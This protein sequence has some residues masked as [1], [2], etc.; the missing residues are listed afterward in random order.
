MLQASTSHY[1]LDED[2]SKRLILKYYEFLLR[3]RDVAKAQFGVGILGNLH[4]FPLNMGPARRGYHEKIAAL[5]DAMKGRAPR[6]RAQ[7]MVHK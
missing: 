2:L 6:V 3:T 7:A 1:T 4:K 5:V